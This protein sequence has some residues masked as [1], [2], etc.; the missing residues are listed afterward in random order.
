MFTHL[1]GDVTADKLS[2]V[3]LPEEVLCMWLR[4]QGPILDFSEF[5]L[6]SVQWVKLLHCIVSARLEATALRMLG[7]VDNSTV[8]NASQHA[9]IQRLCSVLQGVH[10]ACACLRGLKVLQLKNFP[11]HAS[12]VPLLASI[13]ESVSCSLEELCMGYLGF[14]DASGKPKTLSYDSKARQ[15]FFIAV[16]KL[17]KLRVLKLISWNKFIL[18]G[19]S[20]GARTEET[21]AH[22]KQIISPLLQ[23][24]D[25][26]E[27]QVPKVENSLAFTVEPR[28]KFTEATF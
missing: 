13:F 10:S 16:A 1:A 21:K 24:P 15:M 22:V 23:L 17:K 25:L 11:I 12:H 2:V 8:C 27:V 14:R 26:E 20:R 3:D 18:Q 19:V 7:P 28:L 5:S 6:N 9:S 4:C